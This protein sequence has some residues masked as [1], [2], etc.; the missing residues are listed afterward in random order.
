MSTSITEPV[1]RGS[2]LFLLVLRS[3]QDDGHDAVSQTGTK[4]DDR[5]TLDVGIMSSPSNGLTD[6]ETTHP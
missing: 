5:N 3:T 4:S 6:V 2:N 1:V